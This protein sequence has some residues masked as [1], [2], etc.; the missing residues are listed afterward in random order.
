MDIEQSGL[1]ALFHPDID[2]DRGWNFMSDKICSVEGCETLVGKHGAKGMCPKHYS[3]WKKWGNPLEPDHT[4]RPAPPKKCVVEGCDNWASPKAGNGMCIKHYSRYKKYGDPLEP[5]HRYT[6]INK[7]CLVEGCGNIARTRGYCG[8]HYQR[9]M[10]YGDPLY[11]HEWTHYKGTP[12][13][14]CW[15]GMKDRC[16]NPNSAQYKDYGGRGIAVCDRWL[17]PD[18]F[19]HFLEDMGKRPGPDYSIDRID[20]DKGYSPD[21]CKWSN[22]W[23]QNGNRRWKNSSSGINGV[24]KFNEK[25]WVADIIV[26]GKSHTI[27]TKTKEEAIVKRKELEQKY[28]GKELDLN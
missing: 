17:G 23:E 20:N 6:H 19:K 9:M 18:G 4:R 15:N 3:K 13:Y 12:E 7:P 10:K 25:Y 22:R 5:D 11:V 24:R 2:A 28:L 26:R 21:N 27:Y 14:N 8:K 16:R 1:P